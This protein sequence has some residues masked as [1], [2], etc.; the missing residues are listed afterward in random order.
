M[1]TIFL[2][3]GMN[4]RT[5]QAQREIR[6]KMRDK[7]RK[8]FETD[9]LAKYSDIWCIKHKNHAIL[10]VC[11]IINNGEDMMKVVKVVD[12]YDAVCEGGRLAHLGLAIQ[13]MDKCDAIIFDDDWKE[14]K[15]CIIEMEVAKQYGLKIIEV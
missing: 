8:Y 9:A 2:S 7:V 13:K 12:N 15:G 6:S 10:H 11:R 4:G 3:Y 14:H 5:K 1:I